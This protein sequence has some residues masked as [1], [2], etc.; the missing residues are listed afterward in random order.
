M[1]NTLLFSILF[2]LGAQ[3]YAAPYVGKLERYQMDDSF[4]VIHLNDVIE[5]GL[6]QSH[7]QEILKKQ[8]SLYLLD[9]D[10]IFDSFWLPNVNLSLTTNQHVVRGIWKGSKVGNPGNGKTPT[11]T[12]SLDLGEYTVFNWGKDYLGYLNKKAT[13]ERNLES[14]EDSKRDYRHQLIVRYIELLTLKKN[15]KVKKSYLK[16]ASFVYRL[17]KERA[18]LKKIPKREYYFSRSEY[19]EAQHVYHTAKDQVDQFDEQMALEIQDESGTKYLIREDFSYTRIRDSLNRS[20]E[21][22]LTQNPTL[23]N[24]KVINENAKRSYEIAVK[25]NL[26]LPKFSVNLGAYTHTYDRDTNET[27]Y[28]TG[29]ENSNVELVAS[30]S[31]TWNMFGEDGF[32]NKRKLER[33]FI[34]KEL[35]HRR[36]MKASDQVTS[37][38]RTT[39]TS[40]KHDQNKV[41]ILKNKLPSI[42]KH[43]DSVLKRYTEGKEPFLTLQTAQRELTETEVN[44]NNARLSHLK[45]KILLANLLG[46]EELIGESFEKLFTKTSETENNNGAPEDKENG[47][48]SWE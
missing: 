34:E 1:R 12:L 48:T 29:T 27:R 6:R 31:A 25:E 40:I 17:N 38:V 37:S 47:D 8:K 42:R 46:Q 44:L 3:T 28:Y 18:L 30:I 9:K 13:N 39:Y 11:G 41:L 43:F 21:L 36:L 7:H 2:C 16:N 19:L 32:M 15:L 33:S 5:Q 23:K 22:A 4:K 10:S 45:N 20:I 24:Y 35:A 26:P 14:I